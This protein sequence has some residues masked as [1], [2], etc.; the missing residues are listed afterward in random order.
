[1]TP[2][3]CGADAGER[4]GRSASPA[5]EDLQLTTERLGT[6]LDAFAET[7]PERDRRVLVTLLLRSMDPIDRVRLLHPRLLS[8]EQ[9]AILGAIERGG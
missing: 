1:V 9:E 4:P 3:E 6:A 2:T 8:D 5:G 7:L